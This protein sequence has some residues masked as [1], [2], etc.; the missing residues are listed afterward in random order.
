[1]TDPDY[2]GM[3]IAA[4]EH[5]HGKPYGDDAEHCEDCAKEAEAQLRANCLHDGEQADITGLGD[6]MRQMLCQQCGLVRKV[7]R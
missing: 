5:E 2:L 7:E 1:M 3:A 4:V 6:A